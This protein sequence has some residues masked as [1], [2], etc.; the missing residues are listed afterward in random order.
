MIKFFVKKHKFLK[1]YESINFNL[2]TVN[3][4]AQTRRVRYRWTPEL[5]E[6][7]GVFYNIDAEEE[8]TALL[9]EQITNEIDREIINTLRNRSPRNRI[10]EPNRIVPRHQFTE[11][12]D[13]FF[14]RVVGG[15]LLPI[16]R[17]IHSRTLGLDMVSVQPLGEPRGNLMYLDYTYNYPNNLSPFRDT[18][19][20]VE[21]PT[22]LE[23]GWYLGDT[24]ESFGI[25]M[26]LKP[27]DFTTHQ[28][29]NF[30]FIDTAPNMYL[31]R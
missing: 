26:K 24:F 9:S 14:N 15:G 6:D 31:T 1:T 21:E 17:Q 25:R 22:I 2:N 27:H 30:N 3:V 18:T 8:L 20:R 16:S 5:A 23:N 10:L 13:S 28:K 12:N 7:V 11:D 4:E 19:I 29:W